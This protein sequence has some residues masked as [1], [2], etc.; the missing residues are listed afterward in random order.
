MA[1]ER[2]PAGVRESRAYHVIWVVLLLA[3][4]ITIAPAL[5]GQQLSLGALIGAAGCL[6]TAAFAWTRRGIVGLRW[7]LAA[8]IF[9]LVLIAGAVVAALRTP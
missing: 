1:D 2:S 7:V 4:S 3:A 8:V 9:G 6:A 5:A